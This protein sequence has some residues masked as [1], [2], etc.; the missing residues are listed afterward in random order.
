MWRELLLRAEGRAERLSEGRDQMGQRWG[1][2][3]PSAAPRNR[4]RPRSPGFGEAERRWWAALRCGTSLSRRAQ[5]HRAGGR[6]VVAVAQ[7]LRAASKGATLLPAGRRRT[8]V[9]ACIPHPCLRAEGAVPR[10]GW[11]SSA[12]VGG[13]AAPG[14]ALALHAVPGRSGTLHFP[15]RRPWPARGPEVQCWLPGPARGRL[16]VR[17]EGLVEGQAETDTPS[18][19]ALCQRV[20]ALKGV[21]LTYRNTKSDA[22]MACSCPANACGTSYGGR[23]W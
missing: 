17:G 14:Q 21:S 4:P 20:A 6:A 8:T 13:H 7:W 19:A 10:L 12:P 22:S 15:E 5:Q 11:L 2:L 9:R 3:E 1:A 18:A 16:R 23:W